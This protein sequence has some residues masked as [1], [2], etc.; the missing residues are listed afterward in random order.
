M[1]S[2]WTDVAELETLIAAGDYEAAIALWRGPFMDGL[3]VPDC[4]DVQLRF[5]EEGRR[6]EALLSVAL[7]SLASE[8]MKAGQLADALKATDQQLKLDPFDETSLQRAM[9]LEFML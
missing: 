6:V 7:A 3:S 1:I 5:D 2:V 9:R 8:L 4:P